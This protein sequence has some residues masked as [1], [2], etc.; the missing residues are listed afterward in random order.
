MLK[1]ITECVDSSFIS[2]PEIKFGLV[3]PSL[4]DIDNKC[5]SIRIHLSFTHF[6]FEIL[7]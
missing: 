2:V 1:L 7:K 4:H 5:M 3:A 6:L